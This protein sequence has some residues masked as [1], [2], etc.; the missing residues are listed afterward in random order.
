[1]IRRL[2]DFISEYPRV[3][4]L[5]PAFALALLC[6][7]PLHAQVTTP[8]KPA[9]PLKAYG[10][11]LQRGEVKAAE[12]KLQEYLRAH[13]ESE[14]A[15]VLHALALVQLRRSPDAVRELGQ[16]LKSKPDSLVVLKL[17]A[18]LLLQEGKANEATECYEKIVRVLPSDREAHFALGMCYIRARRLKDAED[19]LNRHLE[20]EPRSVDGLAA[21]GTLRLQ[22]GRQ[23]E[24]IPVLQ[25]S[26]KLDPDQPDVR[27]TLAQAYLAEGNTKEAIAELERSV[28]VDPKADP[29]IYLMLARSYLQIPDETK[30]KEVLNRGETYFPASADYWRGIAGILFEVNPEGILTEE[31]I[32]RLVRKFPGDAAG[33]TLYADWAYTKN[34]YDSCRRALQTASTLN[35]REETKIRILALNG[36]M[37]GNNERPGAAEPLL[38]ESYAINRNLH[39]PDERSAMAY[40]EFLE[41]Y[42]RDEEAQRCVSEILSATPGSGA[43]RFSRAKFLAKKGDHEQAIAEANLATTV[44]GN[45]RDF[46]R[47]LHVFLARSYF[48]V[49]KKEEAQKHQLWLEK[50]AAQ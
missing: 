35:P 15:V 7:I 44:A 28:S 36:M 11:M 10:Q 39:F 25:R 42:E 17:Y 47:T 41:R 22:Q 49:G 27:K 1:M 19:E 2:V 21:L 20:I 37:E 8:A 14:R 4:P 43:A 5:P 33:H 45:N 50:H 9:D 48:A 6:A 29:D 30:A 23:K 26:L 34:D 46:L 12:A 31:A 38:R 16:F 40:V 3:A 24:A 18:E 32:R 13:P